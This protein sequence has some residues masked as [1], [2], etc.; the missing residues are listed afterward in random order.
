MYGLRSHVSRPGLV[1]AIWGVHDA[2]I[3]SRVVTLLRYSEKIDYKSDSGSKNPRNYTIL[4]LSKADPY[5]FPCHHYL[6]G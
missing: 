6:K 5:I 4:D 1:G 3:L 2:Q